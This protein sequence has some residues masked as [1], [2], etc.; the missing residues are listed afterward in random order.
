MRRGHHIPGLAHYADAIAG[1]R[2]ENATQ[3]ADIARIYVAREAAL[4]Q[5]PQATELFGIAQ[6]ANER[7][8]T[9]THDHVLRSAERALLST[10]SSK[11]VG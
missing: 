1:F 6:K 8:K 5:I 10:E 2:R 3:L 4:A 9:K 7:L 11:P